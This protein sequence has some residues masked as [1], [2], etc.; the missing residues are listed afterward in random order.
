MNKYLKIAAIHLRDAETS[1]RDWGM[2]DLFVL[3]SCQRLS[4]CIEWCLRYVMLMSG[5]KEMRG[6]NVYNMAC[7]VEVQLSQFK[8]VSKL[9]QVTAYMGKWHTGLGYVKDFKGDTDRAA[10]VMELAKQML[11]DLKTFEPKGVSTISIA[12]RI[13]AVLDRNHSELLAEDVIPHIPIAYLNADNPDM[14][15]L[16][17]VVMTVVKMLYEIR[18]KDK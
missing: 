15:A 5:M 14:A 8:W 16:N 11:N 6:H 10:E 2:D 4:D 1:R 7:Y 3:A 9:L 18:N 13:Q 12:E 17:A